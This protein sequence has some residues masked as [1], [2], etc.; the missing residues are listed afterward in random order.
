MTAAHDAYTDPLTYWSHDG[1]GSIYSQGEH[2]LPICSVEP[3]EIAPG[4]EVSR[5][6][7]AAPQLLDVVRAF[8][9]AADGHAR[10]RAH[11]AAE[12]VLDMVEQP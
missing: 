10:E 3:G 2:G 9:R 11:A 6:I 12:A 8:Q 4:V 7:A 1:A 5:L